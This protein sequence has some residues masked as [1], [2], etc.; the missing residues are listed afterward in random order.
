MRKN[1]NWFKSLFEECKKHKMSYERVLD[2]I[3][4]FKRG[5]KNIL[6]KIKKKKQKRGKL[7]N[8]FGVI[9]NS[10]KESCKYFGGNI[11]ATVR[12]RLNAGW[13]FII[14]YLKPGDGRNSSG[15]FVKI[16]RKFYISISAACRKLGL[17]ISTVHGRRYR[18]WSLKSAFKLRDNEE[19][20]YVDKR[21][22]KY[23]NIYSS[24]KKC[25]KNFKNKFKCDDL[26]PEF[27]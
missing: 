24:L 21:G 23:E 3:K 17:N 25:W 2:Q 11:P 10:F 1:T 14:A 20:E 4:R 19:A 12:Y 7:T 22:Y 26:D 16:N 13:N 6:R 18:G 15:I 5:M 8:L 27:V 9:F